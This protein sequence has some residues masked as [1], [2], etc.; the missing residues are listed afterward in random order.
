MKLRTLAIPLVGLLGFVWVGSAQA[1]PAFA[2]K[3]EKTCNS[4]HTAWPMLNKAGRLF[5]EAGY[6]FASDKDKSQTIGDIKWDSPLFSTILVAR[7]VYKSGDTTKMRALHEV[8]IIAAGRMT[9]KFSGYFELEMEDESQT[10]TVVG[11]GGGTIT[12]PAF[13]WIV[14]P[15]GAITYDLAPSAKIQM[16]WAP[17]SWADPYDTYAP[18]RV[19]TRKPNMVSDHLGGSRQTVNVFGRSGDLFYNV[20]V[21]GNAGDSEPTVSGTG[22]AVTSLG[23][24]AYDVTNDVMVGAIYVADPG[25]TGT[26]TG[27][28]V[29]ADVGK[30]HITA[31]FLNEPIGDTYHVQAAMI[32]KDSSGKPTWVP[33]LSYASDNTGRTYTK[34]HVSYYFSSNAKGFI[35]ALTDSGGS[36]KVT[37]QIA[38]AF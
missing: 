13:N 12:I 35:E 31:A 34:A 28:D 25:A 2:R 29:Q 19:L 26:Q 17:P 20:G 36:D 15:H 23:R 10:Y 7:P 18:N 27:V 30:A 37:V 9:D 38:V 8:E 22:A 32:N 4:C 11:G 3:Y 16:S 5:K 6:K 14:M 24:I 21:A 1:I 33:L